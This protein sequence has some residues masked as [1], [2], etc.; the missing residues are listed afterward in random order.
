MEEYHDALNNPTRKL[1]YPK[2]KGPYRLAVGNFQE[3]VV[4]E[5]PLF[6]EG[7]RYWKAVYEPRNV[8]QPPQEIKRAIHG[9][10]LALV[11]NKQLAIP[12]MDR[13]LELTKP[14]ETFSYRTV[15]AVSATCIPDPTTSGRK[16]EPSSCPTI[17]SLLT[18]PTM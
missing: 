15:E 11:K 12:A 3:I 18:N 1:T 17:G 13:I 16:L 5:A 10:V 8:G 14:R 6:E 7:I 9:Q 2:Y 4:L